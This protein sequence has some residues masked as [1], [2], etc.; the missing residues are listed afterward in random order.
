MN[1]NIYFSHIPKTAGRTITDIFDKESKRKGKKLYVGEKYFLEIIYKKDKYYF[2]T[3]LKEKYHKKFIKFNNEQ[4]KNEHWN[5][6]FWHIPLSFWKDNLLMDLKKNNIIFCVIRNPYTRIVSD[7]KFWIKFYKTYKNK[8]HDYYFKY[9][10]KEIEDIYEMNFVLNKKNMN[11]VIQKILSSSKY[12]Y[13]LDGHL[14]PQHKYV[15]TV[16]NDKLFKIADEILKFENLEKDFIKF[17]KKYIN[18]IPNK[19]IKETHLNPTQNKELSINDLTI[20]TKNIIFNYY[21]LDFKIFNY[22]K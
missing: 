12:N 14:I 19:A 11:K 17:K 8:K 20:N 5:M 22:H 13:T 16:I 9:L 2:D 1:K 15:Y 10:L 4:K 21:K 7:F 18:F 6:R 3:Y